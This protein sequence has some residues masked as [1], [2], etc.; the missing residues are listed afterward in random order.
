MAKAEKRA[1]LAVGGEGASKTP[2]KKAQYTLDERHIQ[3]LRA[4]AFKRAQAQP[5]GYP[6]ASE[7]LREILDG[8]LAKNGKR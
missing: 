1:E 8:W 5:D 3:A 2:R 7:V 6:D 4:E